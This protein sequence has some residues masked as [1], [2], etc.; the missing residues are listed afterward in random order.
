MLMT[1]VYFLLPIV[2]A[3]LF[4][5]ICFGLGLGG[6]YWAVFVTTATEQFG[7]NLRATVTTSV[8][9]FVRGSVVLLTLLF[10]FFKDLWAGHAQ[11][12]L[13]SAAVVGV[14]TFTL[15]FL[16]LYKMQESFH[17]NLDYVE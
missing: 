1:F 7:T 15:A 4:Y 11:G 2:S 3:S 6:G 10:Q 14:I 17:K 16:S 8:P 9:N 5:L 13:W 12:L